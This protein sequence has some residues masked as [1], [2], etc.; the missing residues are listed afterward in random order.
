[1]VNLI[2]FEVL[3]KY[4]KI[5]SLEELLNIF[6]NMLKGAIAGRILVDVK[7]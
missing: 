5:V 2:N 3:E 6:P 1:M 7:K 4:T